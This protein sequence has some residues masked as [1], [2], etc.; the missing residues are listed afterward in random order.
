MV[1]RLD[2]VQE[3]VGSNPAGPTTRVTLPRLFLVM[4]Y[5]LK[6]ICFFFIFSLLAVALLPALPLSEK[7]VE[8]IDF[9]DGVIEKKRCPMDRDYFL[10]LPAVIDPTRT[11]WLICYVHGAHGFGRDDIMSLKHFVA[12]GDCIGVAPSFT[13]GFQL[14]ENKTDEQLIGILHQLGTTYKLH[15]KI[16]VFG[17]SGGG[18]FTHR[19]M[20]KH[21]DLVI[22]CEACSSG[23]WATGGKFGSL[24]SSV[25]NSSDGQARIFHADRDKEVEKADGARRT[26]KSD[27]GCVCTHCLRKTSRSTQYPSGFPASAVDWYEIS[28]LDQSL[29]QNIPIAI[30]CGSKDRGKVGATIQLL[31]SHSRQ[32]R[33]ELVEEEILNRV[34]WFHEFEHQLHQG[35]FFYKSK[36]FQGEA[37]HVDEREQEALAL[38]S[39]SLGTCGMLPEEKAFFDLELAKVQKEMSNH[40]YDFA[41]EQLHQLKMKM[42][43]RSH[44]YLKKE[45]NNHGWSVNEEAL[46]HCHQALGEFLDEEITRI[47]KE[48]QLNP[49][50][51]H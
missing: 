31:S 3:V 29:S 50:I 46:E 1:E 17:H 37:H 26:M 19:F 36:L 16:F 24:F 13:Q 34:Q 14:L 48:A 20:L 44:M 7:R 41:D 15:S 22:A 21:P 23:T 10:Y 51:S 40:K 2:G 32:E 25:P 12:R 6:R 33:L 8:V 38:E 9:N 27:D 49:D 42:E 11:Y 5:N 30:G 39:F 45:L 28:G 35:N 47:K 43:E 4:F 18:Q